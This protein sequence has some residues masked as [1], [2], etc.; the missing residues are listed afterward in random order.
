MNT[1][2]L[3]IR[4]VT[5]R[6]DDETSGKRNGARKTIVE[7]HDDSESQSGVIA[8]D[9]VSL[10]IQRGRSLALV[11]E[12][13][14]GKSTLA[15]MACG[16]LTS[17]S[18]TIS[19]AGL[20]VTGAHGSRLRE[21]Y[22]HVQMVFQNPVESFN[23]RRRLGES[24]IDGAQNAGISRSEAKSRVPKVLSDVGL[25]TDIANRYP[26]QV[27]GGQCQRAAI[28]RAMTFEPDLIVCD[29]ATSALDV[30]VQARIVKLLNDF[31]AQKDVSL[32]FICHDLA[33]A[34]EVSDD[35]AVM[36]DGKI[37]ECGA[38]PEV[39]AHPK[40][41]YTRLLEESVFPS[42]PDHDWKIPSFDNRLSDLT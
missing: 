11:G 29:E 14:A 19:V 35:I 20:Q 37:V 4:N 15:R 7:K 36:R 18:G 38:T 25:P 30:I 26:S 9:G 16:L 28:A 10:S 31:R 13:G 24:I 32:L 39:I 33:V 40:H 8:C 41:P 22:R 1:P 34:S 17:D 23:P 42:A 2:V 6:F 21:V 12:S 5:K 3:N 27:S